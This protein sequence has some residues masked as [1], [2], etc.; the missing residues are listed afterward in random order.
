MTGP[1][2]CRRA[3][4]LMESTTRKGKTAFEPVTVVSDPSPER[5]AMAQA[6]AVLALAAA[7]AVDSD[8][9]EWLDV[10]GGKLSD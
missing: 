9:R 3:E 2:H 6:H 5:V 8:R 1:E 10:A 4:Q 7:T